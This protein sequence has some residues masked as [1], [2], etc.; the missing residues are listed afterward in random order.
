VHY[1]GTLADGTV[2]DNSRERGQPTVLLLIR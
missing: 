1:L 2:F